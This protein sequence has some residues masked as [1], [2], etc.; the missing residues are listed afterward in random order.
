MKSEKYLHQNRKELFD[1]I[2]NNVPEMKREVTLLTNKN[3]NLRNRDI[4]ELIKNICEVIKVNYEEGENTYL[5]YDPFKKIYVR[6]DEFLGK[7]IN[8]AIKEDPGCNLSL[9][10]SKLEVD[11][12]LFLD[13]EIHEAN[14]PPNYI[15]K[16]RNGIFD[17]KNKCFHNGLDE[18]NQPYDFLNMINY[19][20]HSMQD[21]NQE[22]L[23]I[24]KNVFNRWSGNDEETELLLRQICI[25][26]IEGNGRNKYIILKSDGGDGKTTFQY[27]LKLLSGKNNSLNINLHQFNDDNSLKNLSEATKLIYGD[28]L[29]EKFKMTG[30][31]LS[32][33]K[34][35]VSNQPININVKYMPNK[36]I[37]THAL[38]IQNTNSDINFYENND[39]VK[40]RIILINWKHYNYRR[41]PITSFDLDALL[42]RKPNTTINN[43]FI[44]AILAY[45]IENT[46]H[47]DQFHETQQ[48]KDD[49][50]EQLN[51]NDTI[52]LFIDELEDQNIL[53]NSHLP[54]KC[55]Y[56][57]YKQWLYDT[58]PGSKPMKAMEFGTRFGKKI[59]EYGYTKKEKKRLN[60]INNDQFNSN[61][62]NIIIDDKKL[63]NIFINENKI[64]NENNVNE[65]IEIF[66]NKKDIDRIKKYSIE[67]IYKAFQFSSAELRGLILY[68]QTV[69]NKININ[70]INEFIQIFNDYYN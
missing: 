35:I 3:L 52:K 65:I 16:F 58:N 14:I 54:S 21:V 39:A 53:N 40:D 30:V 19:N 62:L 59:K 2:R 4:T 9:T 12:M 42:G 32:N 56:D 60:Q 25:A 28:D 70:E 37:K 15:V 64:L 36:N 61:N 68:D 17:I 13:D 29:L 49:I 31:N 27:I 57:Y 11:Q 22:L 18:N 38:M 45:I 26:A 47:F 43:E 50:T 63:S 41:N 66:K 5:I 46:E 55:M 6:D 10:R 67:E 69:I 23:N 1:D 24:A 20:I 8:V 51:N 48:M 44:E 7:L 34:S 33:F